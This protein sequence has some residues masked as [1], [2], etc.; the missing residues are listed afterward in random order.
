MSQPKTRVIAA[1][2]ASPP[3]HAMSA[4]LAGRVRVERHHT[5][6]IETAAYRREAPDAPAYA[7]RTCAAPSRAASAP[8]G[9]RANGDYLTSEADGF[10]DGEK[11]SSTAA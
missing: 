4:T 8:P 2:A 6:W 9:H 1:R 3:D 7:E 11:S 10:I 5:G